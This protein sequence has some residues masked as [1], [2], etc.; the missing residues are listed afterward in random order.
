MVPFCPA[1][2]TDQICNY[3]NSQN[4]LF[5]HFLKNIPSEFYLNMWNILFYS[6]TFLWIVFESRYT[7]FCKSYSFPPLTHSIFFP[8]INRRIHCFCNGVYH[9]LS[10]IHCRASLSFY[11][12]RQVILQINM[13]GFSFFQKGNIGVPYVGLDRLSPSA[14]KTI[15]YS[16][17]SCFTLLNHL[18]ILLEPFF[19]IS[20][21]NL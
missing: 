19:L 11:I 18:K 2:N 16:H 20:V 10:R 9:L 17:Q 7:I 3:P 14:L 21:Y 8:S 15:P 12:F 4:I 5:F 6:W 1:R 13:R